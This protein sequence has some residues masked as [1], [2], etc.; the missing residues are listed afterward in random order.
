M[1]TSVLQFLVGIHLFLSLTTNKFLLY[2]R[3]LNKMTKDKKLLS[4]DFCKKLSEDFCKKLSED[5]CKKLSEEF[6]KN[7]RRISVKKSLSF[8]TN[9]D[10]GYCLGRVQFTILIFPVIFIRFNFIKQHTKIKI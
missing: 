2:F 3:K 10:S 9:S 5:F 7:C 4:E 6:C 8:F 1:H